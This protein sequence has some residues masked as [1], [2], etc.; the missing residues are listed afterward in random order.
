LELDANYGDALLRAAMILRDVLQKCELRAIPVLR[1]AHSLALWVPLAGGP[2]YSAVRAWLYALCAQAAAE[3]PTMF[4]LEPNA[5]VAGRVHLHVGS[6]APGRH[7]ALPY[8]LS[9]GDQLRT[10]T[11]IAWDE[12][13]NFG[14]GAIAA[15]QFPAR[16]AAVGEVFGA[17]LAQIGDRSLPKPAPPSV[18]TAEV[19]DIHRSGAV[20]PADRMVPVATTDDAWPEVEIPQPPPIDPSTRAL[21]ERLG[22]TAGGSDRTAFAIAVCDAFAHLGFV[23]THVGG[24]R[25]PDGYVDSPLGACGYRAIFACTTGDRVALESEPAA[26]GRY[27]GDYRA[28]AGAVV[29]RVFGERAELADELQ[30]HNV[31]AWSVADLQQLLRIRSNPHEMRALFASGFVADR[32]GDLLWARIH[33][34]A[35]RVTLICRYLREAGWAAQIAFATTNR[36]GSV[37]RA[38]RL[39]IDAAMLLV[40]QRLAE[41][42]SRAVCTRSDVRGAFAYLTSPRVAAA[43]WIDAET[44]DAIAILR[45][46]DETP[47]CSHRHTAGMSDD[48]DARS[49]AQ[50]W[51]NSALP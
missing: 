6:N 8:S 22:T 14:N 29:G 49:K 20:D 30:D 10:C 40:D 33:G 39:S 3:R 42:G 32:I 17:Q 23:A 26:V 45:P 18:V 25:R 13:S 4:S 21:I 12:L 16:L 43:V 1:G 47:D 5:H 7:S 27:T 35:K 31:S 19:T 24:D 28:Q 34:A 50:P 46:A 9:G 38:P 2:L 37:A 15:Q 11:P 44:E 36:E 51:P 48:A 41:E